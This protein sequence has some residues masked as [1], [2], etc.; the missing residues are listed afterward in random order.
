LRGWSRNPDE[1]LKNDPSFRAVPL[2]KAIL[3]AGFLDYVATLDPEGPLFPTIK[4]AKSDGRRGSNA[5]KR[6]CRWIQKNLK[7][8]DPLLEPDHSWRHR[9]KTVFPDDAPDWQRKAIMGHSEPG[10]AG[11]YGE[12]GLR[13][14]Q[15]LINRLRNPLVEIAAEAAE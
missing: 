7:L 4:A 8:T 10:A 1:R 13:K 11:V 12:V 14:A 5:S 15:S 3:D 6:I 2:A 9:F